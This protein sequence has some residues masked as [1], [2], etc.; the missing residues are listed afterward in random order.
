MAAIETRNLTKRY[1][2][3]TALDGLNLEVEAGE[4]FG[5]LGPNG[6]G[7]STTIDLLLGFRDPSDGSATVLGHDVATESRD[8][9]SRIGLLPEGVGVYER[10]S[11]RE[12][13]AYAIETKGATDDPD[14]LLDRTGL[15]ADARDRPAGDYSKGMRQRLALAM[16]LAGDPD[17]LVLDEPSAGLDPGGVADV[18]RIV[19]EAAA[20]GTTVFFS[21]HHLAEV[22]A[23]CDRVGILRAGRLATVDS[24]DGLRATLEPEATVTLDVAED[25]DVPLADCDGVTD[26]EWT[27]S[28]LRATCVVPAA[29]ATVV[30]RVANETT[31]RDVAIEDTSLE[32]L[33]ET[34][35][36]GGDE[37]RAA[38]E[39]AVDRPEVTAA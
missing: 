34:V 14:D 28:R 24:V 29:K 1:G 16:A 12:H 31:V 37:A 13:V 22:E 19:R 32:E 30:Q 7:K 8:V 36:E 17:L 4:V 18:R 6:A 15:A 35:T 3:V 27:G 9:R 2:D 38:D 10:V 33:F 5:F 23:V 25:P 39:G 21:S 11:G 26:V 20:A